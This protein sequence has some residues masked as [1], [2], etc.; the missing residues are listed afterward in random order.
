VNPQNE[1]D[2]VKVTIC[3]PNVAFVD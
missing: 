3:V 1:K 2:L